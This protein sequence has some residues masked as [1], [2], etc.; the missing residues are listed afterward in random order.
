MFYTL[1]FIILS[2]WFWLKEGEHCSVYR[3][4]NMIPDNNKYQFSTQI[5][6]TW[7]SG[8]CTVLSNYSKFARVCV[9]DATMYSSECKGETSRQ[10]QSVLTT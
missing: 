4:W 10:Q 8:S 1:Y 7:K 5:G 3:T 6:P 2:V 9:C